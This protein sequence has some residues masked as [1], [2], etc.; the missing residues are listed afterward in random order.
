MVL[1]GFSNLNDSMNVSR[2]SLGLLQSSALLCSPCKAE[3]LVRPCSSC[4]RSA[5]QPLDPVLLSPAVGGNCCMDHPS[6]PVLGLL[7]LLLSRAMRARVCW[8]VRTLKLGVLS[9]LCA[10]EEGKARERG[11][12]ESGVLGCGVGCPAE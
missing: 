2:I 8:V 9:L 5:N 12:T 11:R 6:S 1:E 7:L 10:E 4:C 3:S